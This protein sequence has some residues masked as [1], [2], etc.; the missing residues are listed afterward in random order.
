MSV[1]G[2][3][4]SE[5][6]AHETTHSQEGSMRAPARMN[7]PG[8][9]ARQPVGPSVS[10]LADVILPGAPDSLHRLLRLCA[11]YMTTDDL[12]LIYAA[13]QVAAKAHEGT[14]RQSGE[15]YIEHPL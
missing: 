3:Q 1:S 14:R 5:P 15:A 12:K 4:T 11:Q 7:Q 13:Y 9:R 10:L 6:T 8:K 2:A